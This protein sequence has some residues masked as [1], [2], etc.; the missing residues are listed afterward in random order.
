MNEVFQITKEASRELANI[1]ETKKQQLL[2][3]LADAI[4]ANAPLLL[5][6]NSADLSRMSRR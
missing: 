6:A 5:E 2:H 1:P 4:E 3:K